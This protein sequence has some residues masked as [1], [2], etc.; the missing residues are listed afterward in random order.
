MPLH[1]MMAG[2]NLFVLS[3]SIAA[4]AF[5]LLCALT[6]TSWR[7]GP[8]GG[9][10]IG[11]SAAT[12]LWAS[13]AVYQGPPTL[14]ESGA[15]GLFDLIRSSGWIVFLVG[16]LMKSWQ[17]SASTP[18]RPMLPVVVVL[19]GAVRRSYTKPPRFG[20][21]WVFSTSRAMTWHGIGSPLWAAADRGTGPAVD[22]W[23]GRCWTAS[24][25]L[26]RSWLTDRQ[27]GIR[28]DVEPCA[29]GR[30]ILRCCA[31]PRSWCASPGPI[32]L[33]ARSR[34][35][36]RRARSPCSSSAAW[37][38]TP[39]RKA[40]HAGRKSMTKGD[41]RRADP[42]GCAGRSLGHKVSVPRDRQPCLSYQT[43]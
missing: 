6:V 1:E 10:L 33:V 22:A 19:R 34:Q 5:L 18:L 39:R 2:A 43:W 30:E 8:L 4:I 11:A 28:S 21:R 24:S 31:S 40:C 36:E 16:V 25:N 42:R 27:A 37:P 35:A 29:A 38:T 26:F 32:F 7:R 41:R 13:Y 23:F 3:H 15:L 20:P 17:G 9:W 14:D 12:A